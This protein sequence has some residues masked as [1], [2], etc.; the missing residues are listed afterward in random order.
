MTFIALELRPWMMLVERTGAKARALADDM[1]IL[2]FG[3]DSAHKLKDALDL[4]H[5]FLIDIGAKIA[6]HKST[7]FSTC[8]KMRAFLRRKIWKVG[9]FY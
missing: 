9:D 4:T 7:T 2:A 6:A 3:D 5:S 1:L 8:E